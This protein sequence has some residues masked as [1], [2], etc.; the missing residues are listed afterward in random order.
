[1]PYL[2][3]IPA[4]EFRSIDYQDF[5]GVTGSPA[6]RGFTLNSQVHSANDL[7]VFVNNVRQEPGVAYTVASTT[8]TMTG[9]VETTDDF[10]VVYQGK[11]TG[12]V[13]VPDGSVTS[14]KLDTN[15]AVAGDLT[16]DTDT[17]HVDSTNNSVGIGTTSPIGKLMVKDGTSS[18]S[19]LVVR[20][21]SEGGSAALS[22]DSIFNNASNTDKEIASIKLGVITNG[23][24]TPNADI[25]FE[26]TQSGTLSEA[27]RIGNSGEVLIGTTTGT[28]R[29]LTVNQDIAGGAVRVVRTTHSDTSTAMMDIIDGDD[30]VS[31]T[32]TILNLDFEDDANVDNAVFIRFQDEGGTIGRIEANSTSVTYHTT[33]DYRLKDNVEEYNSGFDK[34]KNIR[35]VTFDW[36][37]TGTSDVGFIAHELAEHIPNVVSGIKDA[38]TTKEKSDGTIVDVIDP[39][40]VDYGKLTPYL[41]SALKEAINKIETLET[42]MTAL[43]ARVT[44][45]EAN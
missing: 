4:S 40:S 16:V 26:T 38:R 35:P 15:I 18:P 41:T 14:A 9:D 30:A 33:S 21:T 43:T 2:G 37:K 5:T 28:S 10:Y 25:R 23:G 32:R 24:A 31:G 8:L 11:A 19:A 6:K 7:E 29:K 42:E 45:L 17:L 13:S 36:V 39:Q 27:M 1:M 22:L 3:N 20:Q 12:T 34:I 44:A